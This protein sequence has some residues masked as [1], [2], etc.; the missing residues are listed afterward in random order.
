MRPDLVADDMARLVPMLY[1]VLSTMDPD[2]DGWKRY[3]TL[4]LDAISTGERRPLPPAAEF[5]YSSGP[6]SWPL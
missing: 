4:V 3:V 2:G 1:S 5:R 6:H